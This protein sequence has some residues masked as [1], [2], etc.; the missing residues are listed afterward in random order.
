M[1]KL[2][3]MET[4]VILR[5]RKQIEDLRKDYEERLEAYHDGLTHAGDVISR[6]A[7]LVNLGESVPEINLNGYKCPK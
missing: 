7:F 2:T 6:R 5:R 1:L 4:A 3:D